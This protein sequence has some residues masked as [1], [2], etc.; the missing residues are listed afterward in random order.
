MI[1]RAS[2]CL[3]LAIPGL[4]LPARAETLVSPPETPSQFLETPASI[5][6]KIEVSGDKWWAV[7]GDPALDGL[8]ARAEH[9][10]TSIQEAVAHVSK[11]RAQ[12]RGAAAARLP[13]LGVS[14]SA[15]RQSGPLI[16][17]A[18]G[19]G[20]L[21]TAG[22]SLSYELDLFGRL[23]KSQKAAR[24]DADATEDTLRSIRLIVQ[25]DTVDTYFALRALREERAI[26]DDAIESA[27]AMLALAEGRFRNGLAPELDV[28]RAQSLLA[29]TQAEAATIEDRRAQTAH[30]LALLLGETAGEFALANDAIGDPPSIP[31]G[32]PSEVLIRRADIAAA[33]RTLDAAQMRL[34]IAR[35]S[36]FPHIGL[37]AT[38]GTASSA[39]G[40]ILKT[41]A[42]SFGLGLLLSLPIFDGGR[43]KSEVENARAD[44]E[45]AAVAYR[46]QILTAF[47]DVED[48]LSSIRALSERSRAAKSAVDADRRAT[49]IVLRRTENGLSSRL[50]WLDAHRT[51]LKDRQLEVQTRYAQTSAT[52]RLIRAMGGGWPN[53]GGKSSASAPISSR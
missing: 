47:R 1:A 17:A 50:E 10:N 39:L 19:S 25:A 32:I 5:P 27:N 4:S 33:Q 22:A 15:T 14:A 2:F 18:G 31:P 38:G 48:G 43:H 37:T 52:I 21:Y 20:T 53:P 49:Q 6:D 46:R 26:I 11:A 35:A 8:V 3:L 9:G 34:R 41:S 44:L 24:L 28:L 45:L 40:D 51:E 13:E 23:S 16:N 12:L 30:A 7:F 36:W 29:E 42:Q